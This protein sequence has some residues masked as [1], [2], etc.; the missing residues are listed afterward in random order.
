MSRFKL[1]PNPTNAEAGGVLDES[2]YGYPTQRLNSL[3]SDFEAMHTPLYQTEL[4]VKNTLGFVVNEGA[5]IVPVVTPQRR[6]MRPVS[7]DEQP[8]YARARKG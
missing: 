7:V 8:Q 6:T 4:R 1:Y 2:Q 3:W 5:I